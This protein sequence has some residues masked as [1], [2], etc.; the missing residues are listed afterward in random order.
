MRYC[1]RLYSPPKGLFTHSAHPGINTY[2]R[3]HCEYIVLPRHL[4]LTYI[5]L[6]PSIQ[7]PSGGCFCL[8]CAL[9]CASRTL[10]LQSGSLCLLQGSIVFPCLL[11]V[12]RVFIM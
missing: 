4:L 1:G 2:C 6:L 5:H 3:K 9:C 11:P 10:L 8:C 7:T 12:S